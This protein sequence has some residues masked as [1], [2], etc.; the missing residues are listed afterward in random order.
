MIFLFFHMGLQH[1]FSRNFYFHR[2]TMH[3]LQLVFKTVIKGYWQCKANIHIRFR[4]A[5]YDFFLFIFNKTFKG[6]H[7]ED[8]SRAQFS[9]C[10]WIKVSIKLDHILELSICGGKALKYQKMVLA[11]MAQCLH[12]IVSII[13]LWLLVG[14]ISY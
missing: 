11:C 4:F 8:K 7:E 10:L 6:E 9:N 3:M 12:T 13:V 14:M 1:I 2:I 5:F